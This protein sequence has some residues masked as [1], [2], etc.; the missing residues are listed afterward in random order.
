MFFFTASRRSSSGE[1]TDDEPSNNSKGDD[2]KDLEDDGDVKDGKDKELKDKKESTHK[3]L[4]RS[5]RT[6]QLLRLVEIFF[7]APVR[8]VKASLVAV[9]VIG[10]DAQ[11]IGYF[12]LSVNECRL[13]IRAEKKYCQ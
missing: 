2:A 13:G 5:S 7:F 11:S 4:T 6:A 1:E 12:F 9:A 8:S 3:L 10:F